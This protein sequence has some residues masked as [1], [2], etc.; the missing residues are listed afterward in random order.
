VRSADVKMKVSLYSSVLKRI[1][2]FG[3]IQLKCRF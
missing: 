3:G 1:G 2:I